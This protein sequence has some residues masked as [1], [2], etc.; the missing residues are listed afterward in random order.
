MNTP[1][2]TNNQGE[3]TCWWRHEPEDFGVPLEPLKIFWNSALIEND[4][5]SIIELDAEKKFVKSY[6]LGDF[7]HSFSER[8]QAISDA[9]VRG[10]PMKVNQFELYSKSIRDYCLRLEDQVGLPVNCH[11]FWGQPDAGSFGWHTDPCHVWVYM[12]SGTKTMDT[13][14]G[15]YLLNPGDWLYIPYDL[16]HCAFNHTET[17]MLSF[18]TQEWWSNSETLG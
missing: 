6:R 2:F 18:G 12:L 3:P 11:L 4:L 5:I 10:W 8:V 14:A 16:P 17:L 9:Q 7:Y 13:K 1:N 15:T